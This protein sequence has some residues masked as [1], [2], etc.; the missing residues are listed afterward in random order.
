MRL[1][2]NGNIKGIFIFIIHV[3]QLGRNIVFCGTRA[4][5]RIFLPV[6]FFLP[7]ILRNYRVQSK[8]PDCRLF[9]AALQLFILQFNMRKGQRT[10]AT[11]WGHHM[12]LADV[13][14]LRRSA[15]GPFF[16]SPTSHISIWKPSKSATTTTTT[17]TCIWPYNQIHTR[18]DLMKRQLTMKGLP[19]GVRL[20]PTCC[21]AGL[22]DS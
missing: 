6:V 4:E 10:T 11:L 15:H 16:V 8:T 5:N 9:L 14:W 20:L 1:H 17:T 7:H 19:Q 2:V 13:Q 12:W 18:F 22:A 3:R 21:L